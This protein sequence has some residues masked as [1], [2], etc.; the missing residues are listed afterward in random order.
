[1]PLD[2]YL[3]VYQGVSKVMISDEAKLYFADN[4]IYGV[5]PNILETW[6]SD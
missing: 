6:Y 1:M 3:K 2:Q 4:S 5:S